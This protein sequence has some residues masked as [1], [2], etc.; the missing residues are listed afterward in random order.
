ML[1]RRPLHAAAPER[2]ASAAASD[3]PTS[4]SNGSAER[5][6]ASLANSLTHSLER[7]LGGAQSNSG[8]RSSNGNGNG[9]GGSNGNSKNG[10]GNGSNGSATKASSAAADSS[11]T[12]GGLHL[13]SSGDAADAAAAATAAAVTAAAA[14]AQRDAAAVTAVLSLDGPAAVYTWPLPGSDSLVPSSGPVGT[15][16][17]V[18]VEPRVQVPIV[19]VGLARSPD[20]RPPADFRMPHP[21]ALPCERDAWHSASLVAACWGEVVQRGC[22]AWRGAVQ[23][24]LVQCSTGQCSSAAPLNPSILSIYLHPLHLIYLSSPPASYLS[25]PLYGP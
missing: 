5:A 23:C 11:S 1:L 24:S 9:K 6:R 18:A 7:V 19:T 12:P 2:L 17:A 20:G 13:S 3:V 16:D 22:V 15:A 14:L 21:L 8:A 25:S 4:P 10:N